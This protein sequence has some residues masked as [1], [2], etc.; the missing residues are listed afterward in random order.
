VAFFQGLKDASSSINSSCIPLLLYDLVIG[1]A[2]TS[3]LGGPYFVKDEVQ[4]EQQL[5]VLNWG[6]LSWEN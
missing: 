4:V 6:V 5:S 1:V 2:S 3:Q